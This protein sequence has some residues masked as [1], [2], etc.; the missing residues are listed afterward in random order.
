MK[1]GEVFIDRTTKGERGDE[2]MLLQKLLMTVRIGSVL[3]TQEP[4]VL[5]VIE[6]EEVPLAANVQGD[7]YGWTIA[8]MALLLAMFAVAIYLV[9]CNRYRKRIR[10]LDPIGTSYMGWHLGKLKETVLEVEQQ[11]VDNMNSVDRAVKPV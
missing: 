1:L 10:R 9:I 11:S 5:T 8:F 4:Y 2:R 7:F 3:L 6:E